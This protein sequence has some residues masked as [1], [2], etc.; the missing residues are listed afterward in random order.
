MWYVYILGCKDRSFY[1]GTT[2]NLKRRIQ[3]HKEG[4]GGKYT[5]LSKVDK[6]VY[7]EIYFKKEEA[8][9]R[10]KQIKGWRRE[11]KE[12]LIKYGNPIGPR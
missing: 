6:L 8:L 11:K 7:Y 10:E 5:R 1:T 12:N 3:E 4:R 2:P 9:R